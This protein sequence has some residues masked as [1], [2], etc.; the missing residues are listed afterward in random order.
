MQDIKSHLDEKF[1]EFLSILPAQVREL[2]NEETAYFA[3][4]CIR[5]LV[6]GE[7]PK[8]YDIYLTKQSVADALLALEKDIS[9]DLDIV[10]NVFKESKML[11]SYT[12][13]GPDKEVLAAT[14]G[15]Y[16]GKGTQYQLIYIEAGSPE[17]TV[18]AFDFTMNQNFYYKGNLYIHDRPSIMDKQ[19]RINPVA[20][21]VFDTHHRTFKFMERGFKAPP[22]ADITKMAMSLSQMEPIRTQE[23]VRKV[24]R[25]CA[26]SII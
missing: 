15:K 13:Y 6:Y 14:D 23:D 17:D 4:G 2:V 20:R 7:K 19:L 18:A 8:D 3:G 5:S 12:L 16:Q 11:N 1:Q 24:T 21:N 9:L 10:Y 26:S 25:Q 22:K